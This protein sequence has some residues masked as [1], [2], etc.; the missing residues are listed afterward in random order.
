MLGLPSQTGKAYQI[1]NP[2]ALRWSQWAW[3][4]RD[5]WQVTSKL[6]LNLGLRWEYYPFGY[7]DNGNGLRWFNPADGKLGNVLPGQVRSGTPRA[8]PR[9]EAGHPP[10]VASPP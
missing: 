4:F 5:Q 1:A 9:L 8:S 3:Y 10:V 6:T 7:S 2:I